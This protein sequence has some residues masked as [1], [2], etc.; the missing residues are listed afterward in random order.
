MTPT[1]AITSTGIITVE[2]GGFAD[3]D[4]SQDQEIDLADGT[5]TVRFPKGVFS[6]FHRIRFDQPTVDFAKEDL[7]RQQVLY[8]FTIRAFDRSNLKQEVKQ[9]AKPIRISFRYDLKTIGKWDQKD[10]TVVYW[11][12]Q[13]KRWVPVPSIVDQKSHQ[14]IAETNHFTDYGLGE[15]P[16][17]Q[18]YLPSMESFQTDAFT[19][20]AGASYSMEVPAGRGGLQPVLTLS[21]SSQSVDGMDGSSQASFVGTGWQFS[22][23]YIARDTRDTWESDDDAF[24]LVMNGAGYDLVPDPNAAGIYHT[25]NEQFWRISYDQSGDKWLVVTNN[26]TRYEYGWSDNSRAVQARLDNHPV[27]LK[28]EAYAWWLTQVTDVH[29][30]VI[31]YEYWHDTNTT[32]CGDQYHPTRDNAI[33]PQTIQYNGGLTEITLTYTDRTDYNVIYPNNQCGAAPYQ[34][35]KLER[36]DVSTTADGS[37]QLV[38]K[39]SFQYDYSLFPGVWNVHDDGSGAYGR[40]ALKQITH[41]GTDGQTALPAYTLTYN[42]SNLLAQAGNGIGGSV[43]FAYDSVTLGTKTFHRVVTKTTNDGVSPAATWSYAYEGAAVNDA[44]HSAAAQTGNPRAP[45]GSQSRGHSKVTVTDPTGAKTATTFLQDDVMAGRAERVEQ[46]DRDGNPMTVVTNNYAQRTIVPAVAGFPKEGYRLGLGGPLPADYDGDGKTDLALQWQN[47]WH[48][49]PSSTSYTQTVTVQPSWGTGEPADYNGDGKDEVAVFRDDGVWEIRS[50]YPTYG[51]VETHSFAN[52]GPVQPADYDGDGKADPTTRFQNDW[53]L[54]KSS[55]GYTEYIT[56]HT[57]PGTLVPGNYVGDGKADVTVFR[58]DGVFE[59]HSPYPSYGI[60]TTYSLG[61]GS[62]L[63]PA[64]YDGDGKIDPATLWQNHWD[65]LTSTSN[66]TQIIHYPFDAGIA[67]P[68]DYDGDGKAEIAVLAGGETGVQYWKIQNRYLTGESSNFVYLTQTIKETHDGQQSYK[69]TKTTHAYDDYGNLIETDEFENGDAPSAYRKTISTF[70]PNTDPAAWVL[71]KAGS[72]KVVDENGTTVSETR[73]FYDHNASY[74]SPP[75][76]GDLTRVDVSADV[77]TPTN[78][79]PQTQNGYDSYGNLTSVTDAISH[80][81]Q[82]D[83]D[84]SYHTFVTT[85]TNALGQQTGSGYDYR[86]GK[87]AATT[88]PNQATTSYEYDVFGRPTSVTAPLEQGH[89]ATALYDYTLGN[90]RSM[91]HVQVRRDAGGSADPEYQEAWWFYDGLGRVIQQQTTSAHGSIILT[92][93]QYDA[94]GRL[95]R[96]SN[97]YDLSAQ[98]NPVYGYRAFLPE[99]FGG[100]GGPTPTPTPGPAQGGTYVDADWL[101]PYTEHQYDAISR[102]IKTVNP[103]R[104]FQTAQ[105]NQ[106][107][108]TTTDA[109]GHQ[110]R[111]TLDAYGRTI[112]V[113]EFKG[114]QTFTTEYDYDPLDRLS[115]VTDTLNSAITFSYDTLGRKIGM[116]DPDLGVWSYGYDPAGN[117]IQQTDQKEQ[118]TCLYYDALNRLVGKNYQTSASACPGASGTYSVTNRYDEGTH[119][120]GHRT[121][122]TKRDVAS[123]NWTYDLQGRMTSE[124][125]TISGAPAAYETHWTYDAMGRTLEMTYP[126]GEHV[127]MQYDDQGLLET[128]GGYISGSEYNAAGQ[129]LSLNFGDGTATTYAYNSQNLRLTRLQTTGGTE[130]IQDLTY[131]YDAVGNV[132]GLTDG[133]RNE[134]TTYEYDELDRLTSASIAGLYTQTWEYDAVGNITQR[135]DNGTQKNYTYGDPA[136]KHAATAVGGQNYSYDANGNMTDHAGDSLTYDSENRL[137]QVNSS[138]VI[139]DYAYDGAGNRVKKAVT[140]GGTTTTTF[141]VG[142]YFEVTGSSTTKYYYF[143]AQRV[144]MRNAQGVTYLHGDNLGSTSVTSGAVASSQTY[145]AFGGVRTTTGNV[146][147]DFGFTGQRFD[148]DAGLMYYVARYYDPA[149]GRFTQPDTL[150]PDLYDPQSLNRY[151]Y[152]RNNPVRNTDPTGHDPRDQWYHA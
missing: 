126:D 82:Y 127:P 115:V 133:V 149:I 88:D 51:V 32:V 26:G 30:N 99:L 114:G 135:T 74:A 103:D 25:T 104:T 75:F 41:Y 37:M 3:I 138:G 44:A 128:L 9:F 64:D 72:T 10:L 67:V 140:A 8:R 18:T 17:I 53:H 98:G 43:S 87:V 5:V 39:Y 20:S 79:F 65:I 147:T 119:Q 129:L 22:G 148:S 143:G 80:T 117:L 116:S 21:Y 13:K 76:R 62:A 68:G 70:N 7:R 12:A 19:G 113:E 141:Y 33:Y 4:S 60:T 146:P 84:S 57:S 109:S 58:G 102:E 16:D 131:A 34:T 118:R 14:V 122:E 59:I 66:Y 107:T 6:R 78:F 94:L 45:A 81:V 50:P 35:K 112:A 121:G 52:G 40:L 49:Y 63:P 24:S 48:I 2:L 27:R 145:F 136:H 105:F 111:A 11:D 23:S 130:A 61:L 46:L 134:S 86:L 56:V 150:I 124:T 142:N 36:V 54:L 28:T 89:A 71:N 47:Y 120:V 42:S 139:S 85:V 101:Q 90:P 144:A 123:T 73:N 152:V 106:W 1:A 137:T 77:G 31:T 38:R 125:D 92:N 108:T 93:T 96:T 55:S 151:T 132:T 91:V 29:S 110:K 83:Y 95:A 97:P 100:A 69:D 15:A